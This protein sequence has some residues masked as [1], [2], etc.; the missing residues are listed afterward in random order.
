MQSG[1]REFQTKFLHCLDD[2]ASAGQVAE[3]AISIWREIDA[4]LAPIIGQAG[5]AALLR[6]SQYL[7]RGDHPW[8][9]SFQNDMPA[10]AAFESLRAALAAQSA[11]EC[12]RGNG[13]LLQVFHDLLASLIGASLCERLLRSVCPPP[14]SGQ[15]AQDPSR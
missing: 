1:T 14:S 3:V 10:V 15:A 11:D 2:G 5:V 4:A 9:A 13:A 8:L 7:V 6:R 12:T